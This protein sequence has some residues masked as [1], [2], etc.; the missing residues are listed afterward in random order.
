[1]ARIHPENIATTRK[2]KWRGKGAGK[3]RG[4][5]LSSLLSRKRPNAFQNGEKKRR[6]RKEL[7]TPEERGTGRGGEINLIETGS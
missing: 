5:K 6:K 3:E 4:G 2:G 1:M 7:F